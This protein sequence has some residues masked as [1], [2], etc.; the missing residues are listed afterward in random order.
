MRDR[1]RGWAHLDIWG[2]VVEAKAPG[3]NLKVPWL[4][5]VLAFQLDRE[6]TGMLMNPHMVKH[7]SSVRTWSEMFMMVNLKL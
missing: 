4:A 3:S 6:P 5:L 1:S 7:T 2:R